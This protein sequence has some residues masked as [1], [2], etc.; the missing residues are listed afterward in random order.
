[1]QRVSRRSS[2]SI[3]KVVDDD[4]RDMT[5]TTATN[6]DLVGDET[7]LNIARAAL[8]AALVGA[9]A[10]VAFPYPLSPAPVTL[11]V[12][13]VFLA[14]LFLGPLWGGAAMVLYLLTGAL[15]APV[16]SNGGAGIG[17]LLGPTGGYLLSYP[18]AAVAVGAIA[19]GGP[20]LRSLEEASL[21]RLLGGMIAATIVIYGVGVPFLWWNLDVT[22][23]TAVVTGAVV[24]VPAEAAKM[25]A[26]IG[27][28]KSDAI[29]AG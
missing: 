23:R 10:Y 20:G 22:L 18:L 27:I 15:G 13:G 5:D 7:T 14:G 24:F 21:A 9:F 8:F 3:L 25:A 11:Q 17:V 4:A 29:R 26:A 28:A 12:L 1:L 6:V 19:R 16:F 2:T